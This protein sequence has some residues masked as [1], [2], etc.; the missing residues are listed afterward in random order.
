MVIDNVG[1]IL[2]VVIAVVIVMGAMARGIAWI[3]ATRLEKKLYSKFVTQA[4]LEANYYNWDKLQKNYL[5]REKFDDIL[6]PIEDKVEDIEK[7]CDKI[8]AKLDRLLT[9]IGV[10]GITNDTRSGEKVTSS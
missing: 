1:A 6:K 3:V 7:T 4:H 2:S 8:D 10:S 9:A 5:S